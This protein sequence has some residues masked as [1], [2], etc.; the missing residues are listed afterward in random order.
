MR[1]A[2]IALILM[3]GAMVIFAIADTFGLWATAAW[4]AL[5]LLLLAIPI[6]LAFF[7][8]LSHREGEEN[9]SMEEKHELPKRGGLFHG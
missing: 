7:S 3:V 9:S 1:V 2:V 4:S 6:S 5:L 8:F